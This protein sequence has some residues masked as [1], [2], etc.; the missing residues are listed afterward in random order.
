MSLQLLRYYNEDYCALRCT[1]IHM[2]AIMSRLLLL[3]S[4]TAYT[5][6]IARLIVQYSLIVFTL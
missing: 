2:E 3:L 1:L 5:H 4:Y 6:I